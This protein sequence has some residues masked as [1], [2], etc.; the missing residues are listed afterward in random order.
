ME[1]RADSTEKVVE[2]TSLAGARQRLLSKNIKIKA[3]GIL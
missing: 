2:K 3:G 1:K